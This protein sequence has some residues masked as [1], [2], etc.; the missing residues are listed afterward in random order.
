V[1]LVHK[2]IP[3]TSK[4]ATT[5]TVILFAKIRLTTMIPAQISIAQLIEMTRGTLR[6]YNLIRYRKNIFQSSFTPTTSIIKP[7]NAI[8]KT[9]I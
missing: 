8:E 1:P 7:K 3:V 2:S 9:Q 5:K 4:A 6:I